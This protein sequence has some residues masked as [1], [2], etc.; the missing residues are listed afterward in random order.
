MATLATES[1]KAH[2]NPPPTVHWSI[3][4]WSAAHEIKKM[5]P[6][7]FG[8]GPI[9]RMVGLSLGFGALICVGARFAFPQIQFGVAWK[10][11]VAIPIM[12]AC[13][14][15]F[16]LFQLLIPGHIKIT[17][18]YVQC[19]N[20]QH[21]WR[22]NLSE[23]ESSK[24]VIFSADHIRLIIRTSGRTRRITVS[25]A[26]DLKQLT[27]LLGSTVIFDKRGQFK[28]AQATVNRKPTH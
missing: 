22:T 10:A 6:L 28:T 14:A 3:P 13:L 27:D 8:A 11:L 17:K 26:A 23:I 16:L 20:G 2:T 1:P 9:C 18:K 7:V 5:V 12:F 15:G 24:L 4:R 21:G 19:S 25:P